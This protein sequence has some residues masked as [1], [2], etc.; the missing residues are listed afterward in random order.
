MNSRQ[1]E[2]ALLSTGSERRPRRHTRRAGG[3][4]QQEQLSQ[5]IHNLAQA[6]VVGIFSPLVVGAGSGWEKWETDMPRRLAV[7]VQHQEAG[8]TPS[9]S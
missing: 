4:T 9:H 3:K 7:Q 5:H 1:A 2:L 6:A 8:P